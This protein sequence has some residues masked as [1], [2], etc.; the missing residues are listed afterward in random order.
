[1]VLQNAA[2][3]DAFH[4]LGSFTGALG[5]KKEGVSAISVSLAQRVETFGAPV[6]LPNFHGS[7]TARY[8]HPKTLSVDR[9]FVWQRIA[10]FARW[11]ES[12]TPARQSGTSPRTNGGMGQIKVLN[13]S[14]SSL[15]TASAVRLTRYIDEK[16]ESLHRRQT[17]GEVI[18][19]LLS[20]FEIR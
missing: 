2:L 3:H 7:T 17:D 18:R 11:V 15:R 12:S 8:A 6:R 5:S 1:V 10:T 16:G 4:A 19:L 20:H 9:R 13:F 14:E